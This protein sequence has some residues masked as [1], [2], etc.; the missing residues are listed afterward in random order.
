MTDQI[1]LIIS[2]PG[3]NPTDHEGAA[4]LLGI[5]VDKLQGKASYGVPE[6]WFAGPPIPTDETAQALIAR[7]FR[8]V[9]VNSRKLARVPDPELVHAFSFGPEAM[10]L[11]TD[12][13][14]I[15]LPYTT[16]VA[17]VLG[18]PH[19]SAAASLKTRRSS[20]ASFAGMLSVD[21][22]VRGPGQG[23]GAE[24][25]EETAY[26]PFVDLY[27]ATPDG[28]RRFSS[29]LGIVRFQGLG[30]KVQIRASANLEVY[31]DELEGHFPNCRSDRRLVDLVLRD[32][33]P[34]RP[35]ERRVGYSF[36]T[37]QL[38]E[39]LDSIDP[40]LAALPQPDLASRLVFLTL[41]RNRLSGPHPAGS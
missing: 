29:V 18:R 15:E 27:A 28:I 39:L 14:E 20:R 11:Q 10:T 17:I 40:N 7:G 4:R 23:A 8:I 13:G 31:A 22:L 35:D 5:D 25:A 38:R 21:D 37:P 12:N 1:R 32:P 6:I 2:N 19:E 30:D 16:N 36:A 26:Q 41:T 24:G 3:H 9:V 33:N 34:P